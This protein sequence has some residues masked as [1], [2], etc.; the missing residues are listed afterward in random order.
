MRDRLPAEIQVV[1]TPHG[2]RYILP[3]RREGCLRASSIPILLIA[4]AMLFVGGYKALI[5]GGVWDWFNGNA[6]GRPFNLLYTLLGLVFALIGYGALYVGVMLFGGR[7]II[8]TRGNLLI[9]TQRSGPFRWRRKI[10]LDKIKKLQIKSSNTDRDKAKNRMPLCALN[11]F[12]SGSEQ[13]NL[14]W[15]YPKPMMRALAEQLSADRESARGVKLIDDDS[16]GIVIEE[17]MIGQ[18]RMLDA[19]KKAKGEISDTPEA[20]AKPPKPE[21]STIIIEPHDMGVTITVPPVGMRKGGK[22]LYGFSILWNGFMLFVTIAWLFGGKQSGSDWLIILG[23]LALFWTVGLWMLISTI[24]AGRRRAILD[25]VGDTLLITRQ[26]IFKTSQQ[27]IQRDN[28][29][30]IRRDRSGVEVNDEPILNLQIRLHEGKKVSL[31]SQLSDEELSWLAAEL[32]EALGV[33]R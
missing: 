10:A 28:I 24:N 23:V 33:D 13:Y 21:D 17:I 25:V 18:E 8:E 7:S 29:K 22:G 12:V 20:A 15:G 31:F 19:I 1:T 3:T 5:D 11:I 14:A 16:A 26:T 32:R 30:S 4:V 9:A 2:Q 6:T 27:E